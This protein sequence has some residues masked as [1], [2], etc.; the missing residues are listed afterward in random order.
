MEKL[1]PIF[2]LI[3]LYDILPQEH[4]V[5]WQLFENTCSIISSAILSDD[6]IVKAQDLMHQFFINAETLYGSEFVTF[7]MHLHLHI[8]D[9]LRDYGPCYGYW[10]FSFERYNGILGK[11]PTNQRSIEIQLLRHFTHNMHVRSLVNNL[12]LLSDNLLFQKML[13]SKTIGASSETLFEQE[14]YSST[15]L[16]NILSLPEITVTQSMEYFD[17]SFIQLMPPHSLHRFDNDE[18]SHL[19]TCYLTFLPHV[20]PLDIPQLCRKY[21]CIQ[22]TTQ[23]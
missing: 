11:F 5:C 6:Q 8:H 21:K 10:L 4:Y 12:N 22:E 7:N 13:G 19:R 18:I 14:I 15:N 20:N 16:S 2:S 9:V 1:D 23:I 17:K 3:A